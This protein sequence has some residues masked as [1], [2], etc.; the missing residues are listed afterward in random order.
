MKNK[1]TQKYLSYLPFCLVTIYML[2]IPGCTSRES[3]PV[4][5]ADS[6][7]YYSSTHEKLSFQGISLSN[8][9]SKKTGKPIN[10]GTIFR[11]EEKVKLY[12]STANIFSVDE[13]L[14]FHIDW[15][16]SGGNSFYR[17]RIDISPED[18]VSMITSSIS[19]SPQKRLQGNYTIRLYLFRELV[20]EKKFQLLDSAA[21]S[22]IVKEKSKAKL[23]QT[24]KIDFTSKITTVKK[25][26]EPISVNVILCRK[27]SK[28]TGKPIG[29]GTTFTIKEKA[30]VKAIVNVTKPDIKTNEQMKFYFDWI[31]P[32]G[33]SFYKKRIVYTTSN[34]SF[35]ISNSISIT[36]EKRLPGNYTLKVT[37]RKKIIAEKNFTLVLPEQQ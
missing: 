1:S 37:H 15:I 23:K 11:L 6:T 28:K 3:K 5:L 18:S 13:K 10:P 4:T 25:T 32:D 22:L 8:K 14:M 35:T 31:G 17:K 21:Y 19:L 27:I 2:S 36:P 29:A 33:K 24:T 7:L 34:P 20:A 12:A 26:S 30:N 9:I 16:D